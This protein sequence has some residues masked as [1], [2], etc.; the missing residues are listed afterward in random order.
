MPPKAKIWFF[1]WLLFEI[2]LIVIA[3]TRFIL[4]PFNI[5]PFALGGYA[6]VL[7]SAAA[8]YITVVIYRKK[9]RG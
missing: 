8:F 6:I 9:H 4:D 3:L 2:V 1:R 7:A 5:H